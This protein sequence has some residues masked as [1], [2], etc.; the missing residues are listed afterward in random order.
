ML[1]GS[2]IMGVTVLLMHVHYSIDVFS[3]FFISYGVYTF[4]NMIFNQL[5][6]RFKKILEKYGWKRFK[7]QL[8]NK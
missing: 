2:L 5:N 1:I 4:S 3:A 6:V 8:L 7:E